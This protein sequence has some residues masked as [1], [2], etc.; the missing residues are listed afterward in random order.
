MSENLPEFQ[1]FVKPNGPKCNLDCQYC[2]YLDKEQ[3]YPDSKSFRMSG[4]LLE[5]YIK[6]H[7]EATSGPVNH[8]SWHG[9]EPT[10]L[11]LDYFRRIVALQDKYASPQK[12]IVNGIQTNGTL[13]N[14]DWCRFF[15]DNQ[16][17]VGISLDGPQELHDIYRLNRSR[18]STFGKTLAALKLLQKFNI[19]TEILCVV[20]DVNVSHPLKV[21]RYFKELNVRYITFLPLVEHQ[22]DLVN[23]VSPYSVPSK[24]FGVFLSTIFEEWKETD[25]GQVK[26]QIFEEAIRTAFEQDHT[27]CIFKKTCGRVPVLEHNGDFYSCD[28]YVNPDFLIGN[29]REISLA[30]MLIHTNQITFGEAKLDKL[31]HYCRICEVRD[32][33]NGEC[34]KNRF[35]L[36][37]DGEIGLNYLCAGYKYFFNHIKPFVLEVKSQWQRQNIAQQMAKIEAPLKTKPGRNDPCPCGSGKKYKNCCMDS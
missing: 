10:L 8:F 20:N 32:M 33:C 17:V 3:L 28:H 5:E 27:L 29:I 11:G 30:D 1:V 23:P 2:Y 4:E 18:K 34:P 22:P 7:I 14:E 25:I 15:A 37:P 13:L 9:G 31:P 12:Q 36:T 35:I 26:I 6:Q 19:P 16:F 24:A 21:Y